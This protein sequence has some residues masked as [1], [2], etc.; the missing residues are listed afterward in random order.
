MLLALT[1]PP[2]RFRLRLAWSSFR[3]HHQAVAKRCH[4]QR[5]ALQQPVQPRT[6]SIERLAAVDLTLTEERWQR[7]VALL[8]PQKPQR[9][10]PNNDHRAILTGMLWVA[11]TSS[12]WRELP[13]DFGPWATVHSRYRRW[14]QAGIWHRILEVFQDTGTTTPC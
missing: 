14:R 9:G 12:S 1:E 3:R 10:R 7:I 2:E 8:P 4:S 13:A 5:R 11:R 6:P